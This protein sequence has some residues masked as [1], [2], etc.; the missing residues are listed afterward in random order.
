MLGPEL[1]WI[2]PML[3]VKHWLLSYSFELA[4]VHLVH[5]I[6]QHG[7]ILCRVRADKYR[8]ALFFLGKQILTHLLDTVLVEPVERLVKD[9]YLWVFHNRLCKPEPLSH[10]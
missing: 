5:G 3:T 10:S 4:L 8:L 9:K 7:N 6:A 2:K 1:F